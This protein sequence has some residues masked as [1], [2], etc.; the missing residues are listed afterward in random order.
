MNDTFVWTVLALGNKI[1][2]VTLPSKTSAKMV[3]G[4]L[5]K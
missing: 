4:K 2:P 1:K 5:S 3:A